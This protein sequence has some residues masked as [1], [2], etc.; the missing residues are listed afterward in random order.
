MIV[1]PLPVVGT[2]ETETC[3]ELSVVD[4]GEHVHWGGGEK[5]Q[6]QSFCVTL[7][8]KGNGGNK[9][10]PAKVVIEHPPPV[11]VTPEMETCTGGA[12]C[13]S[14]WR[15]CPL[16]GVTKTQRSASLPQD[17]ESI[18]WVSADWTYMW[19][20]GLRSHCLW[21]HS[22]TVVNSNL[23]LAALEHWGAVTQP[24]KPP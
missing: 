22:R 6:L 19:T 24:R 4:C 5:P 14:L 15:T 21:M 3:T 7:F 8:S 18:P 12:E 23:N 1:Q 17:G 10:I 9:T 20:G 16:G 2:P 13:S 11:V